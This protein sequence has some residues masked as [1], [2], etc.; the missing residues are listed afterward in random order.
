MYLSPTWALAFIHIALPPSIRQHILRPDLAAGMKR[1]S[2]LPSAA[3]EFQRRAGLAFSGI[4]HACLWKIH[5]LLLKLEN[6][7]VPT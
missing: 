6:K 4:W 7:E 3:W 1:A 2:C 5:S